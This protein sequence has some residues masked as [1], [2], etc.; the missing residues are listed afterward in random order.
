M[1]FRKPRV[2][3]IQSV[4]TWFNPEE[5]ST[6]VH[7]LVET[8]LYPVLSHFKPLPKGELPHLQLLLTKF[9]VAVCFISAASLVTLHQTLFTSVALLVL[10][11]LSRPT[12]VFLRLMFRWCRVSILSASIELISFEMLYFLRQLTCTAFLEL[13]YLSRFICT[14]TLV[15]LHFCCFTWSLDPI[16]LHCFT[17]IHFDRTRVNVP[18]VLRVKLCQ[19]FFKRW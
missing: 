18:L 1:P 2:Y 19:Q 6:K 12:C 14:N 10:L 5:L 8:S 13:L 7:S 3:C 4:K 16:H 17:W 11:H 15:L 9:R